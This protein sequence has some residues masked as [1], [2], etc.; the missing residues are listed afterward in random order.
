M[1]CAKKV[2]IAELFVAGRIF[3]GDNRC[4]SPQDE[5]PRSKGE[6]YTKCK[7][8]CNQPGHAE[9]VAISEAQKWGIDPEGGHMNVYHKRVCDNCKTIM[10]KHKMTWEIKNG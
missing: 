8:I 5:C 4:L 6:D 7:I 2:V 1:T 9:E 3:T 10:K